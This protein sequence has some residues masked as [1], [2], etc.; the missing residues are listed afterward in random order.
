MGQPIGILR[1]HVTPLTRQALQQI[2]KGD[3]PAVDR[4]AIQSD[5]SVLGR[6]LL[7]R[8]EADVA[9]FE[10]PTLRNVLVTA[11]YFHDGSM[12]TLWDVMD[13]Y[14]KGDGLKEPLA[15]R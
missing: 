14:H 1:H 5:F 2:E 15:R 8:K 4:A 13:H 6:F 12:E 11:P 3:L 9:S 7:T 10:T